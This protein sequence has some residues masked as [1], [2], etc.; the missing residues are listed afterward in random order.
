[1]LK[2][3]PLPFTLSIPGMDRDI[4]GISTFSIMLVLAFLLASYL[5]PRE[6]KRRNLNP[7]ITDWGILIAV[8]GTVIGAKIGFVFEVWHQ[9]WIVDESWSDT[10]YHILAYRR[11]M[12][13][14]LPGIGAIGLWEA[15]FSGG[16]LVFYGGFIAG[17]GSLYVY[18]KYN[19][20][21]IWTH[22]DAFIPSMAV[23]YAIGRMGCMVSGDGCYGHGA[24]IDI[25]LFTM[26]Y[27]PMSV[28]SS[29]GV[30]VWNTPVMESL[31]S[32][33]L[34]IWMMK[35]GRYANYKAG[36]LVAVFLVVNGIARFLVEFIRLNDALIPVLNPP[37]IEIAAG[38]HVLLSYESAIQAG[39]GPEYYFQHWHWYGFTQ[40]QIVGVLL[41]AVGLIWIFSKKL[42]VK[43]K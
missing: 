27:G 36:F 17:F 30:N 19:K 26:V 22:G 8:I 13:E 33:L 42:Y 21:D 25:P 35:W 4:T 37:Q 31:I 24:S 3:I 39:A 5:V 29:Y 41:V 38:H 6:L 23:G 18:L 43:Q 16:G 15:L 40:S 11:G 1:M 14:K 32:L 2:E 7:E 34:F 9:I 28:I 20:L 12:G 10:L